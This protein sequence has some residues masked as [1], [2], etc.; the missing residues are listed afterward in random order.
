MKCLDYDELIQAAKAAADAAYAPYSN[1]HVG[2][3]VLTDSGEIFT[4]CNIENASY[5]L[6]ICAE[7]VAIFKAR[8]SGFSKWQALAIFA[9]QKPAPTPC[10][11]CRQVMSEEENSPVVI[12]VDGN[13]EIQRYEFDELLPH[14]FRL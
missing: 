6:T 9:P 13:N 3:A 7:R 11:A 4:G 14:P 8:S 1:Y 10:G 5:G 2:A 12:I